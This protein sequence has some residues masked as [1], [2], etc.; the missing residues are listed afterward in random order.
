[1]NDHSAILEAIRQRPDDAA[2]RS[3]L[4]G[5]LADNGGDREAAA[6]GFAFFLRRTFT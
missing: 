3:T 2:C 6:V 1:M 4:A 5:W